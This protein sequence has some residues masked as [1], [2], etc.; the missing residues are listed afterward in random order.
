[1]QSGQLASC[2]SGPS[3][4][5]AELFSSPCGCR[6]TKERDWHWYQHSHFTDFCCSGCQLWQSEK[7]EETMFYC[8]SEKNGNGGRKEGCVQMLHNILRS[9]VTLSVSGLFGVRKAADRGDF[10][11]VNPWRRVC[12]PARAH[13]R[14]PPVV[15]AA[16]PLSAHVRCSQH[17][18]PEAWD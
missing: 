2:V 6:L 3:P 18:V 16:A 11:E 8:V 17:S 10:S 13:S 1:M 7:D 12:K 5:E 4:G 15:S 9:S 14:L